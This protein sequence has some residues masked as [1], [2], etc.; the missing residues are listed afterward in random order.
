MR[1]WV[2][3]VTYWRAG[4]EDGDKRSDQVLPQWRKRVD[5]FIDPEHTFFSLGTTSSGPCPV[6]IDKVI[7]VG[8][9]FTKPYDNAWNYARSGFLS[10][11]YYALLNRDKWDVLLHVQD[12]TMVGVPIRP[13]LEDFVKSDD[14]L[15]GPSWS[16]DF[17]PD[18]NPETGFIG[19]KEEGVREFVTRCQRASLMLEHTFSLEEEC[20]Q[21]MGDRWWNPWPEFKTTRRRDVI[22]P[23]EESRLLTDEEFYRLPVVSGGKHCSDEQLAKWSELH[24]LDA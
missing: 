12:R 11:L 19:F 3:A 17:V 4:D 18:V 10:G 8:L 9:E 16:S 1:V 23:I 15:F 22:W 13:L 2:Y 5:R 7:D 20:R 24:P 14:I 21:L 6:T